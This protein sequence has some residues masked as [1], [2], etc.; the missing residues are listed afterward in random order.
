[1]HIG[2]VERSTACASCKSAPAL[3]PDVSH[4]ASQEASHVIRQAA[5]RTELY[6]AARSRKEDAHARQRHTK[7]VSQVDAK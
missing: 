7:A 5:Q 6:R 3:H 4:W 2:W 1:M